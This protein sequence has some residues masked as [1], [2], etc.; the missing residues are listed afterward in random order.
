MSSAAISEL[1]ETESP[2]TLL[3]PDLDNE[4][5][6]TRRMLERLPDG[7][8]D[9]R[10]HPKSRSLGEL[11]THLAQ[12]PG[13]GIAQITQDV[14]DGTA[15]PPKVNVSNNAD[16]LRLFDQVSGEFRRQ[17][18][19][20]TWERARAPWSMTVNGRVVIRGARSDIL[21]SVY[22]MHSAHHRAQ[23]GVY[24][25]LLDIPVPFSY[26]DS[27]DERPPVPQADGA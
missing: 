15:G 3:F 11:A 16:R 19:Q 13:F 14:V 27:A 5:A 18:Q 6:T 21:R 20:L 26:G 1:I 10:P 23:L 2:A 25:R 24:L 4:L 9:W 7:K 22:F 8:D 17:L 12:L